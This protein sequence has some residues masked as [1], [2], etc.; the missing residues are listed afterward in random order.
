[1]G[2]HAATG[3]QNT[4]FRLAQK[5]SHVP[6][7]QQHPEDFDAFVRRDLPAGRLGTVEEIS[8]VV[9]FLLS[10]RASRVNG[11]DLAVDGAQGRP[12]AR[13]Y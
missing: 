1:M 2:E 11:T 9:T 8:D 10:D 4:T 6:V 5:D 3:R 12:S 13:G 7:A